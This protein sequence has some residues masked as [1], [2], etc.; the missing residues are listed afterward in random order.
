[1][2]VDISVLQLAL[3][4]IVAVLTSIIGGLAGYGTGALMPLV[5]VPIVGPE[6]VVP[7]IALSALFTNASRAIAFHTAVNWRRAAIVLVLRPRGLG[8][9]D[10]ERP[11][12]HDPDR[13][14]NDRECAGAAPGAAP[15]VQ[16]GG[17]CAGGGGG[18]MEDDRGRDD[19]RRGYPAFDAVGGRPQRRRRDRDRRCDLDRG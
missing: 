15:R 10:P 19:R 16:A 4:A 5:L 2:L 12:G 17:S 13:D 7:I 11:R 1:M 8:L 14:R 3:I 6:P 9:H 18:R